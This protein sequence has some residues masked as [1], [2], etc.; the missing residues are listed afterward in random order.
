[1]GYQA[2]EE[3]L[4]ADL[5]V[6]P[7]SH[8]IVGLGHVHDGSGADGAEEVCHRFSREGLQGPFPLG[9]AEVFGDLGQWAAPARRP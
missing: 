5:N 9:V 8:M 4:V 1:M 3:S 6:P 7:C 2:K